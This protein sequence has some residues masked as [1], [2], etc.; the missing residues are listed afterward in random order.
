MSSN[1]KRRQRQFKVQEFVLINISHTQKTL[2]HFICFSTSL[3]HFLKNPFQYFTEHVCHL[4]QQD[5]QTDEQQMIKVINMCLP[6][7]V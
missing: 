4:L 6:A 7:Y 5:G 3:L 1:D 2:T